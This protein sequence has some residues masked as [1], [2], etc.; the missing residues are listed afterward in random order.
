V[1]N[2]KKKKTKIYGWR[3]V[4]SIGISTKISINHGKSKTGLKNTEIIV[5]LGKIDQI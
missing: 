2:E 3:I 5:P 1:G 4:N